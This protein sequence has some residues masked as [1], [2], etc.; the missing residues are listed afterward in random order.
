MSRARLFRAHRKHAWGAE[1]GLAP[2]FVPRTE[3]EETRRAARDWLRERDDDAMG[4]FG[5][6]SEGLLRAEAMKALCVVI[7]VVSLS[8]CMSVNQEVF[9][10]AVTACDDYG[11]LKAV[12]AVGYGNLEVTCKD[13]RQMQLQGK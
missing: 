11:G 13:G 5:G 3:H 2:E 6:K 12:W 7:G 4:S 1:P 10:Q 9:D 8:A